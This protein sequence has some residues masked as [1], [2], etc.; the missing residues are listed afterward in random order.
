MRVVCIWREGQDYSR[1]V[2]EWLT[3]F[4]RRTGKEVENLDPDTA[5]GE[6]FCRAYDIVEYPTLIALDTNGAVLAMWRG[7]MLPRFDEVAYW[8]QG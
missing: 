1:M 4:G 5:D 8:L 2:E 6:G 3:E 7:E